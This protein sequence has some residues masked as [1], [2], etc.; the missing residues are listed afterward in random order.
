MK[1]ILVIFVSASQLAIRGCLDRVY[2]GLKFSDLNYSELIIYWVRQQFRTPLSVVRTILSNIQESMKRKKDRCS[3]LVPL[4]LKHCRADPR[5]PL[6]L[7]PPSCLG[8]SP[9]PC[10]SWRPDTGTTPTRMRKICGRFSH[11]ICFFLWCVL[12]E[13]FAMEE[14]TKRGI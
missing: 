2:R 9:S 13:L 3:H 12:P 11:V 1:L 8:S 5:L 14:F 10:S 4:A 7:R 6:P